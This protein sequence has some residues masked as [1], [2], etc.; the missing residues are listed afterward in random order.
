MVVDVCASQLPD[1]NDERRK[2]LADNEDGIFARH[3]RSWDVFGPLVLRSVIATE[4]APVT[5]TSST[6]S[7]R[8]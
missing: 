8:S 6:I 3:N 2:S 1:A 5:S 4:F 7:T